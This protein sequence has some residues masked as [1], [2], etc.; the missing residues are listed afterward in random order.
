MGDLEDNVFE[1]AYETTFCATHVLHDGGQPIEP[2]HGHDWRVEVVAAGDALDRLEPT[3][4]VKLVLGGRDGYDWARDLVR[5]RALAERCTVLFSPVH[6]ALEPARLVQWILEDGL[7]VRL[8]LQLHK[9]L[10]PGVER[11]V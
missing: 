1:V 2:Q 11:G 8:Q 6:E 3:D 5:T 9:T 10:W 7:P 4:E